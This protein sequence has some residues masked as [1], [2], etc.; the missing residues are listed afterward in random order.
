MISKL[1]HQ[2]GN[3]A[4]TIQ[5]IQRAA[6]LIEAELMKFH[7]IPQLTESILKIQNSSEVF[8]GYWEQSR[9]LGVISYKIEN[10]KVDIHRLAVI[11]DHFRKGIAGKLIRFLLREFQGMDFVVSTGKANVPAKNL[12]KIFGFLESKD[13]EVAPGVFCTSLEKRGNGG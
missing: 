7:G 5:K 12:Y 13:F 11:P 6:Y 3:T 1:D 4:E 2:N 9:L 8:F 10:G